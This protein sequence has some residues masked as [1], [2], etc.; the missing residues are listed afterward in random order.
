MIEEVDVLA[1]R[2]PS[3]RMLL[4]GA[5]TSRIDSAVVEQLVKYR[6]AQW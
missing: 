1:R 5:W 4:N 6:S 3:F 2:S